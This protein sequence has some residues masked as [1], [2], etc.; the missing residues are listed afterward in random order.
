MNTVIGF[1]ALSHTHYRV[2]YSTTFSAASWWPLIPS[3]AGT[4]AEIIMTN[5]LPSTPAT[6]YRVVRAD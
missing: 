3:V 1:L 5:A 2:A 6:F 4:V